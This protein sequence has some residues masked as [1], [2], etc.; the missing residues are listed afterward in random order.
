MLAFFCLPDHESQ[1][2]GAWMERTLPMKTM[3]NPKVAFQ[4]KNKEMAKSLSI[5]LML[6]L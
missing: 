1:G 4:K 5:F 2:F 3:P 6:F